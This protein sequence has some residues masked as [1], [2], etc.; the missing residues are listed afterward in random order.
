MEEN[1]CVH[2]NA[3]YW[4]R[5]IRIN[6]KE[7]SFSMQ[8]HFLESSKLSFFLEV[9]FIILSCYLCFHLLSWE[10]CTFHFMQNIFK[11]LAN[12]INKIRVWTCLLW[13][14]TNLKEIQWQE[15]NDPLIKRTIFM[16]SKEFVVPIN[17]QFSKQH[18]ASHIIWINNLKKTE[19]CS[20]CCRVFHLLMLDGQS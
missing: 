2:I 10:S 3:D 4:T 7:T 9:C 13:I 18:D 15:Y 1:V 19:E 11:E 6:S 14:Y 5:Y 8:G 12:N 20:V 17:L 16:N